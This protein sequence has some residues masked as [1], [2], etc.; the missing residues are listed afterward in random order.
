[1]SHFNVNFSICEAILG[2]EKQIGLH[3]VVELPDQKQAARVRNIGGPGCA[4]PVFVIFMI[5]IVK[6]PFVLPRK[7]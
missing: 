6:V 3:R 4:L 1:M 5:S 2:V 7:R